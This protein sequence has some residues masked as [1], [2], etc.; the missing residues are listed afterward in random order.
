MKK[1]KIVDF[2]NVFSSKSQSLIAKHQLSKTQKLSPLSLT[3]LPPLAKAKPEYI[4]NLPK[5][6]DFRFMDKIKLS[7]ENIKNIMES[8]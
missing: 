7:E 5:V 4:T 6:E 8:L 3:P 2:S 1:D